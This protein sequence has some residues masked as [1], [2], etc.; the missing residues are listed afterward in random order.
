[1][2]G[3]SAAGVLSA[4]PLEVL[5]REGRAGELVRLEQAAERFE[6][7]CGDGV[8][9]WRRWGEGAPVVLLH[10][11]G[12]SWNHWLR[13]IPMLVARERTVWAPD[14]PG[15]GESALPEG[16]RTP[17]DYIAPLVEAVAQL[18][19]ADARFDLVAFSMGGEFAIPLAAQLPG[20]VRQLVLVGVNLYGHL[21]PDMFPTRE[22]RLADPAERDAAIYDNF[23]TIMLHDPA[24]IDELAL[25]MQHDNLARRRFSAKMLP[26]LVPA[27]LAMLDL[28]AGV[29][30]HAI[31]GS[32]DVV[33]FGKLEAQAQALAG[34]SPQGQFRVIAGGS[35]WVMYDRAEAFNQ[36]LAGML[37]L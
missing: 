32:N 22:R 14:L 8:S 25:A 9:V 28:P 1:M 18:L 5:R 31:N 3:V 11:G 27:R 33:L 26:V 6:I 36:C 21:S 24:A 7:P 34:A 2:H 19:P 4:P 17:A 23:R 16:V 10:G 35:H 29:V 13:T 20:R 37:G 15:L 12:G 30:L